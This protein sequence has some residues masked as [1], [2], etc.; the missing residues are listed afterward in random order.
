MGDEPV[1]LW[2]PLAAVSP[3][4]AATTAA[5]PRR[6]AFV[7][8]VIGVRSTGQP[9]SRAA[10]PLE[11]TFARTKLSSPVD[12]A[13]RQKAEGTSSR[14]SKER[15]AGHNP[16]LR[17]RPERAWR[18]W[19]PRWPPIVAGATKVAVVRSWTPLG[20]QPGKPPA[21]MNHRKCT[22][23]SPEVQAV[24]GCWSRFRPPA[25][26][27]PVRRSAGWCDPCG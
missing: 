18:W 5:L 7:V 8:L 27:T 24:A 19:R 11:K 6:V 12:A 17:A 2:R 4:Q 9:P 21:I 26:S 16:L 1:A 3:D 22:R 23:A 13:K 15:P 25:G 20:E 10:A 14:S